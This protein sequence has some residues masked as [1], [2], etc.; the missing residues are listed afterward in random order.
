[1]SKPLRIALG[2]LVVALVCVPAAIVFQDVKKSAWT[3]NAESNIRDSAVLIRVYRKENG[4]YPK[5]MAE[6]FD[7]SDFPSAKKLAG[8][9]GCPNSH[10]EYHVVSNGFALDV[11]R[12][13]GVFRSEWRVSQKFV[14]E[15]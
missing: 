12:S 1:M 13:H 11:V 7:G 14:E 6:V 2:V 15:Q 3:Q 8:L 9:V 5:S 4:S 10:Y